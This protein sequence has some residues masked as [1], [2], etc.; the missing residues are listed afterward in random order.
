MCLKCIS[1]NSICDVF[2]PLERGTAVDKEASKRGNSRARK[3]RRD[4]LIEN[5]FGVDS[6]EREHK[7]KLKQITLDPST[8]RT[9]WLVRELQMADTWRYLP[10]NVLEAAFASEGHFT[11]FMK[12]GSVESLPATVIVSMALEFTRLY[13]LS[14]NPYNREQ[15]RK[16]YGVDG[17]AQRYEAM[18]ELVLLGAILQ[19]DIRAKELEDA[20]EDGVPQT[21]TDFVFD[22]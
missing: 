22:D 10:R 11:K 12:T 9:L 8:Q 1:G 13:L 19:R 21:D 18:H 4:Y 17:N 15:M 20:M 16:W 6:R 7:E 14:A 3:K 5:L 2:N